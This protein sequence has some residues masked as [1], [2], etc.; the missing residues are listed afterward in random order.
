M[1]RNVGSGDRVLRGAGGLAMLTCAVVAPLS[2]AARVAVF[3]VTGAYL[4]F[5][6]FAGTCLCYALLGK[7]TCS[8]EPRR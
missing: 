2:L 3:G 6:A 8:T 7:S 4:L 1:K 5:S